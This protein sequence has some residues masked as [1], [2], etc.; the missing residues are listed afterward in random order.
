MGEMAKGVG[1]G[2][3]GVLLKPQAGLWGLI[4]YPLNG[5]S[6]SIEKSYGNNR[7]DY[8][9]FSRIRQGDADLAAA[10]EDEKTQILARWQALQ[11]K[12]KQARARRAMP[13]H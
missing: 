10:S 9:I 6:R 2:V 11:L 4:G 3:G 8:I 13:F 1:K 5:V 12:R 7:Q